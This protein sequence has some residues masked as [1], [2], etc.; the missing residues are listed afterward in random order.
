MGSVRSRRARRRTAAVAVVVGLIIGAV[1]CAPPPS[2]V[3]D[4]Q[5]VSESTLTDYVDGYVCNNTTWIS[6]DG[7]TF[8]A[9]R[10]GLLTTVSLRAR[11]VS[12]SSAPLAI[13]I[14][15]LRADGAPSES[16]VGSGSYSGPGVAN[17]SGQSV[18]DIRLEHPAAVV[19]GTRYALVVN[20]PPVTG[21]PSVSTYGWYLAGTADLYSTGELWARGNLYGRSDWQPVYGGANDLIFTTWVTC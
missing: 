7:Q 1:A 14:R 3:V 8:T 19:A 9:G 10:T 16:V 12:A 20:V 2:S 6:E 17:I 15:T 21:C 4:Q 18:V 11:P 5:N 13:S